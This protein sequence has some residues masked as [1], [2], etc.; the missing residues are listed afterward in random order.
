M[1]CENVVNTPYNLLYLIIYLF[2]TEEMQEFIEDDSR[3]D[4][5]KTDSCRRCGEECDVNCNEAFL[6]TGECATKELKFK[7][8]IAPFW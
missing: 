5:D 4:C 8:L 2:M 6:C 3:C 1:T 7:M